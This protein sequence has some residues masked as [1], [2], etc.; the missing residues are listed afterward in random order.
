MVWTG[1]L[2]AYHM[3]VQFVPRLVFRLVSQ[4]SLFE[5]P[6][7]ALAVFRFPLSLDL[8]VP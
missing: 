3:L 4:V 5:I 6:S 7:N 2:P 1:Y 8:G